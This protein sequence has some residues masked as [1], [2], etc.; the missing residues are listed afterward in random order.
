VFEVGNGSDRR[1]SAELEAM[2]D[3]V[4][5][6]GLGQASQRNHAQAAHFKLAYVLGLRDH[7]ACRHSAGP[8]PWC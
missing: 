1:M 7:A 2:T 4:S 8:C 6:S 5:A 3:W